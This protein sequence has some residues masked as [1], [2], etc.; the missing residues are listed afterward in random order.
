MFSAGGL[1]RGSNFSFSCPGGGY[2]NRLS[3][4]SGLAIDQMTAY[5]STNSYQKQLG[6]SIG[7]GSFDTGILSGFQSMNII[8]GGFS[9]MNM[10]VG[11][12]FFGFSAN[13]LLTIGGVGWNSMNFDCGPGK[14]LIGFQ[15]YADNYIMQLGPLCGVG[16]PVFS[17]VGLSS[18]SPFNFVCPGGGYVNRLSGRDGI[19]LDSM[20]AYCSTNSFQY[21]MGTSMGGD[22][23]DTGVLSGF[24]GMNIEV[25]SFISANMVVGANFVSGAGN[26]VLTIGSATT[27]INFGCGPGH[28]IIGFQ[29]YANGVIMQLGP[30][31]GVAC[32]LGCAACSSGSVCTACNSGYYFGSNTCYLSCPVK[33]Y[34]VGSTCLTCPT[35][36]VSCSNSTLCTACSTG[37]Y[38]YSR[39]C[40]LTCPIG[41]YI[42]G[43]TCVAQNFQPSL[44]ST[45]RP[46]L[47]ATG[48][49]P[50][51]FTVRSDSC[52]FAAWKGCCPFGYPYADRSLKYCYASCPSRTGP[53][54]NRTCQ[55]CGTGCVS[56][57]SFSVYVCTA[58]SA[59]YYL[60]ANKSISVCAACPTGCAFCSMRSSGLF[61]VRDNADVTVKSEDQ[62]SFLAVAVAVPLAVLTVCCAGI[63]F[64][65]KK[66]QR[67]SEQKALEDSRN[68][69]LARE[70]LTNLGNSEWQWCDDQGNWI[71]YLITDQFEI[72]T[73]FQCSK[74]QVV[75]SSK[76]NN[77][78]QTYIIDVKNLTQ[79]NTA[80]GT[81][82]R[83]QRTCKTN[84]EENFAAQDPQLQLQQYPSHWTEISNTAQTS[85]LTVVLDNNSLEYK[86]VSQLFSSTFGSSKYTLNAI[87][88]VQNRNLY[89]EYQLHRF[90]LVRELREDGINEMTLFHGTSQSAVDSICMDGFDWRHSGKNGTVW[91]HGSY[92]AKN[93]KYS[94]DF[95]PE[96]GSGECRMFLASVLVGKSFLGSGN[97]RIPPTGFHTAV[98]NENPPTIFVIFQTKQAYPEYLIRFKKVSTAPI[99]F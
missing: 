16:V 99:N 29:G 77:C 80:S 72:E 34:F 28:V 12:K 73:A 19:G 90:A 39:A 24:Q 83:I 50:S 95:A 3:G 5:C 86:N 74:D 45:V 20:N 27:N 13:I 62:V 63:L 93:S 76:H 18:G 23:Y 21:Q 22:P 64:W 70:K 10:V 79:T 78:S 49:C 4:R 55:T 41:T 85:F 25:G 61:C 46:S 75:I 14:L 92:F 82:K 32:P 52:C 44:K 57:S 84:R 67:E 51:G 65:K 66:K 11:A 30:F 42:S 37:Y 59:G 6:S 81:S 36:C 53:D 88:R 96:D 94:A 97:V 7:G 38:F 8:I 54:A 71:P 33:T 68:A 31:C 60:T 87:Y 1:A 17:P 9:A 69:Q 40:Y 47:K 35:G 58:C 91:G 43:S 98:N 48:V 89:L 56:C 26:I 2:V 15:G